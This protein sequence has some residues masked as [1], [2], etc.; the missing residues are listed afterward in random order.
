MTKKSGIL[1]GGIIL[2][3][4]A[5][6]AAYLLLRPTPTPEEVKNPVDE[7]FQ[8]LEIVLNDVEAQVLQPESNV[9]SLFNVMDA[10]RWQQHGRDG[11]ERQK[12]NL[13][14]DHKRNV[15]MTFRKVAQERGL[16]LSHPHLDDV[17]SISE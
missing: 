5:A 13:Y 16:A 4:G 1:S 2:A 6:V 7:Q 14:L 10:L 17:E 9:D 8:R 3:G 11:Y 12:F 15:A